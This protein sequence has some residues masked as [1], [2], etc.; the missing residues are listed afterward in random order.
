MGT[1]TIV[2]GLAFVFLTILPFVLIAMSRKKQ[3]SKIAG[4]L[5]NLASEHSCKIDSF[6]ILSGVAIGIDEQQKMLFYYRLHEN[7]EITQILKFTDIKKVKAV[8][9]NSN[10]SLFN[11]L[12]LI[13]S[14]HNKD[15]VDM[16]LELYS[17]HAPL[18]QS[19]EMEIAKKWQDKI[20][21][22]L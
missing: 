5:S 16:A 21:N 22:L 13:F 3:A 2:I 17:S 15:K 18:E 20:N 12:E 10:Q 14:F 1:G 19:E 4:A 9:V 7:E 8:C 6:E 11:K